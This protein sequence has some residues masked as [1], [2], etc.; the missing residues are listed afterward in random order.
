M[1]LNPSWE[2][3]SCS[4]TVEFPNILWNPSVRYIVHKSPP[5]V[6]VLSLI[7]YNSN[8][9]INML[10]WAYNSCRKRCFILGSH[11]FVKMTAGAQ[12]SKGRDHRHRILP[13]ACR[14][15][16]DWLHAS[17]IKPEEDT[18]LSPLSW[19]GSLVSWIR[20]RVKKKLN[21]RNACGIFYLSV[22]YLKSLGVGI[23]QSL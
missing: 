5:L 14:Q 6:P 12:D 21:S 23:A 4:A 16:K 11:V 18:K 22:F 13:Q 3:S 17:Q 15:S 19:N 2:A 20:E 10:I 9:Y 8:V 1:E 7:I